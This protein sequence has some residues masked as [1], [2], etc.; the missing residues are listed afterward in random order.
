LRNLPSAIA[1][2][3][4]ARSRYDRCNVAAL[5]APPL[6]A[7]L[8]V[9]DPTVAVAIATAQPIGDRRR[10]LARPDDAVAVR[11]EAIDE[12]AP[13]RRAAVLDLAELAI[14]TSE[15]TREPAQ[16]ADRVPALARIEA[17]VVVAIEARDDRRAQGS[18]TRR[19]RR[20]RR[21]RRVRI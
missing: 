19:R 15:L 1:F 9:V 2:C 6:P 8:D 13:A 7:E 10:Q 4:P 21:R 11:V 3:V 14:V 17:A 18:R 12:R 20:G 5:G 16:R